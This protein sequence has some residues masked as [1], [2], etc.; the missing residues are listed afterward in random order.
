VFNIAD[1]SIFIGVVI[2]LIMQKKYFKHEEDNKSVE[3]IPSELSDS[4]LSGTENTPTET[5]QK[6]ETS[7]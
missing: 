6:P 4:T 5:N 2:I 7:A 1:S 3:S